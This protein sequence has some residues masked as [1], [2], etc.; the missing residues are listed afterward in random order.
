VKEISNKKKLLAHDKDPMLNA[1]KIR[2]AANM[3]EVEARK[4]PLPQLA[5]GHNSRPA[6]TAGEWTLR[7]AVFKQ[8]NTFPSY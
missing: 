8:V 5:F 4:L 2:V 7:T 1:Y 6:I 3:T